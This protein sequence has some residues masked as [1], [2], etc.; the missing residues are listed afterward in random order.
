MHESVGTYETLI[1]DCRKLWK[2]AI[3]AISD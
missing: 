3:N 1:N 2:E